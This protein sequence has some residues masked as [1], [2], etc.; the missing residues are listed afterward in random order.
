MA[1]YKENQCKFI[2]YNEIKQIIISICKIDSIHDDKIENNPFKKKKI[3]IDEK[4]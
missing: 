1:F 3:N 4:K 2:Y